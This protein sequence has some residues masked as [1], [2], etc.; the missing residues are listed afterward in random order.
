MRLGCLP[1]PGRSRR[2]RHASAERLPPRARCATIFGLRDTLHRSDTMRADRSLL[3]SFG[4]SLF[5]APTLANAALAQRTFVASNG[6]DADPCSITAPCRKFA[7]AISESYRWRRSHRRRLRRLWT[8]NDHQVGFDHRACGRLRWGDGVLGRRHHDQ[9]ARC[10]CRAARFVDQ[11][12]GRREW[13]SAQGC[14]S[15]SRRELRRLEHGSARHLPPGEQRRDD[16]ARLDRSRQ[17]RWS[18]RWS[19][20]TRQFCSIMC[21]PNTTSE[22]R[23]LHR[24]HRRRRRRKR[25]DRGQRRHP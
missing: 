12:A 9:R 19:H 21:A 16:C 13:H 4:F 18:S 20:R 2:Q 8:G 23:V 14:E 15:S 11:R 10:D 25:D 7:V 24:A 6:N 5:L 3:F 1:P 22:Q 17:R